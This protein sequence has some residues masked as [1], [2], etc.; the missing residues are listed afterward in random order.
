MSEERRAVFLP[1]GGNVRQTFFLALQEQDHAKTNAVAAPI[2]KRFDPGI[3]T[4]Q[5]FS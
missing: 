5:F 4:L 3:S 2:A 1:A